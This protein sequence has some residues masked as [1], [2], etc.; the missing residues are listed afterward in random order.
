M[1]AIRMSGKLVSE[2]ARQFHPSFDRNEPPAQRRVPKTTTLWRRVVVVVVSPRHHIQFD[3]SRCARVGL[4]SGMV[5]ELLSRHKHAL[6]WLH[7]IAVLGS[8]CVAIPMI[9]W[10]AELSPLR[11][12]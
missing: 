2:A 9:A 3:A 8:L 5:A 4:R 6:H 10:S 11:A 1:I 7:I 12:L